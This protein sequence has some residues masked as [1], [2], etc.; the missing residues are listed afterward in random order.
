MAVSRRLL[1]RVLEEY[2]DMAE[3]LRLSLSERLRTMNAELGQ[4]R[5]QLLA[6]DGP[7]P[8]PGQAD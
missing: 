4:T 1:R 3:R 7:A 5:E 2:P 8:E 6:I